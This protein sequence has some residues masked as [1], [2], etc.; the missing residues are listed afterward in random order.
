[1]Q[2]LLDSSQFNAVSMYAYSLSVSDMIFLPFFMLKNPLIYF[3]LFLQT[4]YYSYITDGKNGKGGPNTNRSIQNRRIWA[5]KFPGETKMMS[6]SDNLSKIFW[7]TMPLLSYAPVF[8]CEWLCTR[9]KHYNF[10]HHCNCVNIKFL[11]AFKSCHFYKRQ[12]LFKMFSMFF[13]LLQLMY[14]HFNRIVN[15]V[16]V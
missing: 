1:M 8:R 11:K 3:I 12:P 10:K 7:G 15:G 16:A 4:I 5:K 6:D 2:F 13:L 9:R 14:M